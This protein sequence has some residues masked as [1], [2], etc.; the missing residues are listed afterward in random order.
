M[1]FFS[2]ARALS[3][4][5]HL[6]I[7][8]YKIKRIKNFGVYCYAPGFPS[9]SLLAGF[10]SGLYLLKRLKEIKTNL[11]SV[12]HNGAISKVQVRPFSMVSALYLLNR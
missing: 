1:H 8:A 5:K 10:E 12:N 3:N 11:Q 6:N 7:D 9:V 4:Q 2:V